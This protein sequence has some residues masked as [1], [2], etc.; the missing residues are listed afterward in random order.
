MLTSEKKMI[1]VAFD[2]LKRSEKYF[3]LVSTVLPR[4]I[5]IVS[6]LN[7]GG[8]D[9]LASFSYFNVVSSEP[10]CLMFS[11]TSKKSGKKDTL[12]N[13]EREKEFVI[14]I[15]SADQKEPIHHTGEDL[16]YGQSEREKIGLTLAPSTW[17][18]TPRVAEF[19][20]AYECVLERII[21]I[22]NN[23]V[24]FGR[25]LGAHIREDLK[26]PNEWKVNGTLLN[27]LAR[28][29]PGYGSIVDL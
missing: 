21:E 11:I 4:P 24:V 19:P 1:S 16:P 2:D 20:I 23:Q 7:D 25:I 5:A 22:G 28:M 14:H 13:V 3:M 12:I 10:P 17:I 27:P 9:N 6:T 15:G 26:I 18:K 29:E 8:T